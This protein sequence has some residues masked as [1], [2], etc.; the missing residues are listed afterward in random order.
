MVSLFLLLLITGACALVL[1]LITHET[2]ITHPDPE[3][4]EPLTTTD[5]VRGLTRRALLK[6]EFGRSMM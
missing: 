3:V 1:V 6:D 5:P 4:A 2:V